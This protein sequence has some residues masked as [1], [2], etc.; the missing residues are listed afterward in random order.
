MSNKIKQLQSNSIKTLASIFEVIKKQPK[1][2]V[3]GVGIG[4][5][6]TGPFPGGMA[7]G[8]IGIGTIAGSFFVKEQ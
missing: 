8:L 1:G 7:I 6:F 5:F 2:F 4:I 3:L